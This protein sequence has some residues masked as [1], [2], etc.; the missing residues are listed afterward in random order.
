MPEASRQASI[1]RTQQIADAYG[2][3]MLKNAWYGPSLADLLART[4]PD[5]A[6]TPPAAG[7]HS[8]ST[9][10]QH[11]LLWNDRVLDTCDSTPMPR[12]EPEKEW[13]APPIPWNELVV[14]WNRSRDQMEEKIRNFPVEDLAKQVP[15]RNYPYEKLLGGIVEHAIYH[16]GQIAMILGMFQ[17]KAR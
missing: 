4:S 9:L 14:R 6:A 12:W 11:I 1:T 2:A 10:L 17:R 3:A 16:S 7:A 5:I 8:I 13:A 15:G